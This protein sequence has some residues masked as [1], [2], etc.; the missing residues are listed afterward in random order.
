MASETQPQSHLG[1]CQCGA[2]RFRTANQPVRV[3]ACHC[4]TCKQRTGSAYGIGVYHKEE[5]VEFLQGKLRTFEFHSSESGR[6]LRNEFCE[7]CGATVTWTLEMRPGLRGIA[8][9]NYDNPGWFHVQAHIWT[10]SARDDVRYP[11]DM[12]LCLQALS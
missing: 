8:G 1:G 7:T 11:D 10:E 9:G 5:D 4:S 6:W 3:I 2:V 12:K